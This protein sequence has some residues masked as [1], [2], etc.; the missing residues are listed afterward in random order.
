MVSIRIL[1]GE[2]ETVIPCEK[3]SVI[4][5][6]CCRC[7]CYARDGDSAFIETYRRGYV[8]IGSSCGIVR[9][10]RNDCGFIYSIYCCGFA[11]GISCLVFELEG[12]SVIPCEGVIRIRI[13]GYCN[14]FVTT[15]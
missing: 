8:L 9:Y 11:S 5:N 12:E 13:I 15:H 7:P 2:G 14:G 1:V 10:H 4:W 6:I 3:M